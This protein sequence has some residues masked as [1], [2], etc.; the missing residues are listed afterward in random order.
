MNDIAAFMLCRLPLGQAFCDVFP[1]ATG[2]VYTHSNVGTSLMSLG[3]FCVCCAP[4]V[5]FRIPCCR[6]AAACPASSFLPLPWYILLSLFMLFLK[7][8][9][10]EIYLCPYMNHSAF[11]IFFIS[12]YQRFQPGLLAY[13]FP[14]NTAPSKIPAAFHDHCHQHA[15]FI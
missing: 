2:S 9:A 11:N 4:G 14:M 10:I 3:P 13:L 8:F 6:P 1:G 12:I 7:I 15:I 5:T